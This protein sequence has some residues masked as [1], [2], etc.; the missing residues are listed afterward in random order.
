M[1]KD[2]YSFCK[3]C[4]KQWVDYLQNYPTTEVADMFCS[5]V[6]KDNMYA[7]QTLKVIRKKH[8]DLYTEI[9]RRIK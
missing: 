1:K 4:A 5:F 9:M 2:D 7:K 6:T 8:K 3:Q